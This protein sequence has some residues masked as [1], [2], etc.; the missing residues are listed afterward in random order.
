MPHEV[1]L[2]H[3]PTSATQ[4]PGIIISGPVGI[5]PRLN[6]PVLS[7]RPGMQKCVWVLL[8]VPELAVAAAPNVP[9]NRELKGIGPPLRPAQGLDDQELVPMAPRIKHGLHGVRLITKICWSVRACAA[10]TMSSTSCTSHR[11]ANCPQIQQTKTV[12]NACHGAVVVHSIA[13]TYP[14]RVAVGMSEYCA[15]KAYSEGT[16]DMSRSFLAIKPGV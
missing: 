10:S 9:P 15:L 11:E 4:T 1:D 6:L 8:L 14:F 7:D 3:N 13:C 5:G 16:S 12:G 2:K